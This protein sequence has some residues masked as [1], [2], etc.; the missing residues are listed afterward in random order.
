MYK[1]TSFHAPRVLFTNLSLMS[2]REKSNLTQKPEAAESKNF[3]H[4]NWI[5]KSGVN[6]KKR[7]LGN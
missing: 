1:E 5:L 4:P 6:G 3:G 7:P 2:M